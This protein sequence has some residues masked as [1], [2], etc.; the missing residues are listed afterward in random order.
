MTRAITT[1]VKDFVLSNHEDF[2]AKVNLITK[3]LQHTPLPAGYFMINPYNTKAHNNPT[4]PVANGPHGVIGPIIKFSIITYP[5]NIFSSNSFSDLATIHD[6]A[7][8]PQTFTAVLIMSKILSTASIRPMASSG[9]PSDPSIRAKVTVPADGTAAVPIEV[10]I[11]N[12]TICPYCTRVKSTPTVLAIN[13]VAN[14]CIIA[15]PSIFMVAPT[16]TTNA[17]TSF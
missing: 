14:P 16:G 17:E 4:K 15:V 3:F 7:A 8:S 10:T 12:K 13:I 2:C 11:A 1:G 5:L 6:T 9:N